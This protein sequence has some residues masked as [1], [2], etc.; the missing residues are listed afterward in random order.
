MPAL[1]KKHRSGGWCFA[2]CD[3]AKGGI[4]HCP[5]ITFFIRIT[6]SRMLLLLYTVIYTSLWIFAIATEVSMQALVSGLMKWK[7]RLT[8]SCWYSLSTSLTVHYAAKWSG[9]IVVPETAYCLISNRKVAAS[10]YSSGMAKHLLV[11]RSLVPKHHCFSSVPLL[12][13]TL[14]RSASLTLNLRLHQSPLRHAATV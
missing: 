5:P 10:R 11:S 1:L 2:I 4:V 6:N 7:L 9:T 8:V 14:V 12:Y 13:F 3:V